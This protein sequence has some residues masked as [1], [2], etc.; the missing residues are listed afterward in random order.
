M[1]PRDLSSRDLMESDSSCRGLAE[2]N[3]DSPLVGKGHGVIGKCSWTLQT[4]AMDSVW[5]EEVAKL[6]TCDM[7]RCSSSLVLQEATNGHLDLRIG[8]K[9]RASCRK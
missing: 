7:Q 8:S 6:M 3:R 2:R 9:T 4:M 5:V 1:E